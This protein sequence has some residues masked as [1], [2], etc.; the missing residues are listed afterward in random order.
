MEVA[1]RSSRT[2]TTV[3]SRMR[4]TIGSSASEPV[5]QAFQSLFTSRHVR[6][7]A[8]LPTV[9][10][11]QGCE[12]APHPPRIGA[13]ERLRWIEHHEQPVTAQMTS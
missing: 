7:T 2:Q 8:S 12:R 13:G 9:S 1:L 6:L 10:A 11:E 3:P 5:F 4:R